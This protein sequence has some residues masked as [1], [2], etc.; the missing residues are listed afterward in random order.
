MEN[1]SVRLFENL[2]NTMY[3]S[4]STNAD[5]QKAS[6]TLTDLTSNMNFLGLAQQ[7]LENSTNLFALS[8]VGTSL[9][10]LLTQF[11]NNL[12]DTQRNEIRDYVLN[13]LTS[14][15]TK[16]PTSV[17]LPLISLVCRITKLSWAN[18]MNQR[19]LLDNI[20][21]FLGKDI[22]YALLGLQ[23]FTE[24]VTQF[25][26]PSSSNE[27]T[28]HRKVSILF[29]DSALLEVI[30]T[31]FSILEKINSNSFS[32][33]QN[34]NEKQE[35]LYSSLNLVLK[36]LSYDFTGATIDETSEEVGTIQIPSKWELYMSNKSLLE[37]LFNLYYSCYPPTTVTCLQCLLMMTSMRRSLFVKPESRLEFLKVLIEGVSE[38]LTRSHG[39]DDQDTYHMFCQ[40]LGKLKANFQLSELFRTPRYSEFIRL[41]TNFTIDSFKNWQWCSNSISY[42]LT[43]WSR[44][45]C[46]ERYVQIS[47]DIDN[48]SYFN[49]AVP[50]LI[51]AY[52]NGR[53]ESVDDYV[54][55]DMNNPL[56]DT[57]SL[58]IEMQ[59]LPQIVRY[60]YQ[61]NTTYICN[62]FDPLNEEY[63]TLLRQLSTVGVETPNYQELARKMKIVEARLA[64][65]C[66]IIGTVVSGQVFSEVQIQNGHQILDSELCKRVIQLA[67]NANYKLTNT[68]G[69][70]KIDPNLELAI[71]S[72][73]E[74]FRKT[75]IY[76][77]KKRLPDDAFLDMDFSRK[78][79]AKADFFQRLSIGDYSNV[80]NHLM[81]IILN[82]LRY[83]EDNTMIIKNSLDIFLNLCNDH[84]CSQLLL[85]ISTTQYLLEKHTEDVFHFLSNPN[86]NRL[87]TIYYTSLSTL[88]FI[89]NIPGHLNEFI[90]PMINTLE[91]ICTND[92]SLPN[93]QTM[94]MNVFRDLRGIIEGATDKFNYNAVFNI[95]YKLSFDVI[96]KGIREQSSNTYMLI[97]MFKFLSSLCLNRNSR[98]DAYSD[99]S[100]LLYKLITTV[101]NEYIQRILNIIAHTTT[102]GS[103]AYKL[104]KSIFVIYS[105][106]LG[107]KYL[108]HG[109]F[110]AYSDSTLFEC[111]NNYIQLMIT[112]NGDRLSSFPKTNRAVYSL[113]EVLFSNYMEIIANINESMF[114]A[115]MDLLTVGTNSFDLEIVSKAS[116]A[117][118]S[119]CTYI[120]INKFNNKEVVDKLT[121]RFPSSEFWTIFLFGDTP[122]HWQI[123][124]TL[125]AIYL[126]KREVLETYKQEMLA[127]Q[128]SSA[129]NI[130]RLNDHFNILFS[131]ISMSLSRNEQDK[132]TKKCLEFKEQVLKFLIL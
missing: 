42:L 52:I 112:L 32:A 48:T 96:L 47:S 41:L 91:Y 81:D 66:N 132:F 54:D 33:F 104:L 31:A 25:N 128:Q 98:I 130:A 115:I 8:I 121:S 46:A 27:R 40:L 129:E 105:R 56:S 69:V 13:Y 108:P 37:L 68:N 44:L 53:I 38:Q 90:R 35:L 109:I 45:I 75:Y 95:I 7:I 65:F 20:N 89:E 11:W 51:Q 113:L 9:T 116:R 71:L 117:L 21:A 97:P 79:Q 124:S 123:S 58:A 3:G 24:L 84:A 67:N 99:A 55:D 118:N 131:N 64:W 14:N 23:F 94:F 102:V 57:E 16:I 122:A 2:C 61:V 100:V 111:I 70:S 106:L 15:G 43:L 83:W 28:E 77:N 93:V 120:Y 103:D 12:S 88:L 6:E 76:E 126:I 87:R 17:R 30:K 26:I 74:Q 107:G 73:F 63:N 72:F 50:Q 4:A 59:Q 22:P 49:E 62:C 80:L 110:S 127:S 86:Y 34:E 1:N 92:L 18:D 60:C 39:F 36:C 119:F 125:L 85:D 82:N 78:E 10:R 29:R 101:M 19:A 114:L 5:K